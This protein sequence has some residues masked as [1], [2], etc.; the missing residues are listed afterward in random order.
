MPKLL[1]CFYSA[2]QFNSEET[3]ENLKRHGGFIP[4]IGEDTLYKFRLEDA[5][6]E[7]REKVDPM[8]RFSEQAPTNASIVYESKYVWSDDEWIARRENS[9]AHAEPSRPTSRR[10]ASPTSSCCP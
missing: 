2:V 6:G 8:A 7:W 4:G 3:S 9:K 10:W 5:N 1:L